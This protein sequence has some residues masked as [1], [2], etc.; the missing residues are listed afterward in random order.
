[1]PRLEQTQQAFFDALQMPLRGTSRENTELPPNDEGHSGE[2]LTT[3][4]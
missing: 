4:E 3:A 1:M 2:F